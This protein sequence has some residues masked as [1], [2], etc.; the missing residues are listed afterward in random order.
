MGV[1]MNIWDKSLEAAKAEYHPE[2]V[3]PFID[4]HHV[5]CALEA[6]NGEHPCRFM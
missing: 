3:S 4:A 6:E 2:K 5:A 1:I